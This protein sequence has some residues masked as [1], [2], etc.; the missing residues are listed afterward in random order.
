MVVV[1]VHVH[2]AIVRRLL[3]LMTTLV[4]ARMDRGT[5]IV[6]AR[7]SRTP[8]RASRVRRPEYPDYDERDGPSRPRSRLTGS[9]LEVPAEQAMDPTATRSG[10]LVRSIYV[11]PHVEVERGLVLPVQSAL[12]RTSS[13]TMEHMH[14]D[15]LHDPGHGLATEST[16]YFSSTNCSRSRP[17]TLSLSL[18]RFS[19][20]TE[21]ATHYNCPRSSTFLDV[22][23]VSNPSLSKLDAHDLDPHAHDHII[24]SNLS[25]YKV[26]VHAHDLDPP[27]VPIAVTNLSLFNEV[28]LDLD[29]LNVE[30]TIPV[31][32][33]S[34]FSNLTQDDATR[35]L[36]LVIHLHRSLF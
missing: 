6:R 4:F 21:S 30:D 20:F 29:H 31:P 19:T 33:N 15:A 24:L 17:S 3:G 14:L 28:D 23:I 16:L 10:F 36:V 9:L 18:S 7:H 26:Q 12:R 5:V 35:V 11:P 22:H 32:N 34:S 1:D 27:D 25:S 13:C 8:S 2:P